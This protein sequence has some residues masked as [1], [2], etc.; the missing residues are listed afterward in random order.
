MQ[1]GGDRVD[2]TKLITSIMSL[3]SPEAEIAQLHI[4]NDNVLGG[5]NRGRCRY[6]A[7]D[8]RLVIARAA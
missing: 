7:A 3:M 4:V 6:T 5:V 2:V 1:R 8:G